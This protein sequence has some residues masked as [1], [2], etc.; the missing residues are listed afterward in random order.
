MSS[1]SDIDDLF[2][3]GA[4]YDEG[5]GVGDYGGGY[6]DGEAYDEGDDCMAV[7]PAQ[8]GSF[9][10]ALQQRLQ[11]MDGT[12]QLSPE[13]MAA[14]AK[15]HGELVGNHGTAKRV[16]HE[17]EEWQRVGAKGTKGR[18][19]RVA[20]STGVRADPRFGYQW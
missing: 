16:K 4:G 7:V 13:Q 10:V 8:E 15:V 18:T 17:S 1:E 3:D 12:V 5:M 9:V 11:N 6:D 2:A 20:A 14:V 19:Q